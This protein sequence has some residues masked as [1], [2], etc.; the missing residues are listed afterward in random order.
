MTRKQT[1][2]YNDEI[3]TLKFPHRFGSKGCNAAEP[4]QPCGYNDDQCEFCGSY[5]IRTTHDYIDHMNGGDPGFTE[6]RNCGA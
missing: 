1:T 6:C 2:C 4:R 5:E 3:C